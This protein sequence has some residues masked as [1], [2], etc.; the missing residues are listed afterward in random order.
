[1][2]LQ[3]QN[4]KSNQ[5]KDAFLASMFGGAINYSDEEEDDEE[6]SLSFSEFRAVN[7]KR[8]Q[9]WADDNV[10]FLDQRQKKMEE[11]RKRRKLASKQEKI[12]EK[13]VLGSKGGK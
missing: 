2:C 7:R 13:K 8:K 11:N 9:T 5:R 1:M 6:E 3:L 4:E 10:N 12:V